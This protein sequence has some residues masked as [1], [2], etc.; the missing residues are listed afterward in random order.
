MY[1]RLRRIYIRKPKNMPKERPMIGEDPEISVNVGYDL[2]EALRIQELARVADRADALREQEPEVAELLDIVNHSLPDV[3][4]ASAALR[5]AAKMARETA[6]E[7]EI[8]STV[9]RLSTALEKERET[10]AEIAMRKLEEYLASLERGMKVVFQRIGAPAAALVALSV[11]TEGLARSHN[12][13]ILDE[14]SSIVAELGDWGAHGGPER[15][16]RQGIR[17]LLQAKKEFETTKKDWER[18]VDEEQ[19]RLDEEAQIEEWRKEGLKELKQQMDQMGEEIIEQATHPS[20]PKKSSKSPIAK[21]GKNVLG[22][23]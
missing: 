14:S 1:E 18:A 10:P 12:T 2:N 9:D 23:H 19:K 17:T 7:N 11:A 6:A 20:A 13:T 3:A 21:P 4:E 16:V 15:A 8:R 22:S 5:E